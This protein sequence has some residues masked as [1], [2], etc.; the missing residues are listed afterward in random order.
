ML[1]LSDEKISLPLL[2]VLGEEMATLES[3]LPFDL[4]KEF[5][6]NTFIHLSNSVV[7]NYTKKEFLTNS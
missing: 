2:R 6:F 5:G 1:F 7:L 3:E 4:I